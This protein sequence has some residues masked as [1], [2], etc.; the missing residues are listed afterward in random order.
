MRDMLLI[1]VTAAAAMGV[2]HRLRLPSVPFLVLAG[3]G[4]AALGLVHDGNLFQEALL[5]G[6]AFLVF[7]AGTEM[8]P[9]RM[10]EQQKAA[11]Q[12][13]LAQ[14]LAFMFIGMVFGLAFGFDWL[15]ALYLALALAASSTLIVIRLLKQRQQLFEP[16]GRLV[17]GVL[18]LQDGLIILAIAALSGV[19]GELT[20]VLVNVNA[21]LG[22]MLLAYISLRWVTPWLLLQFELDEEEKLL[23]ALAILFLFI[24]AASLI[25]VPVIIGAFLA[26]VALSSF[27]VSGILRGQLASLSDFFTALFFVTLGALLTLPTGRELLLAL[28][29]TAVVLLFT[30]ILVNVIARRAGVSARS[31]LESGFLL[32]QTSEFSLILG[33]IGIQQGHL[34]EGLLS[35]LAITTVLTMMATPLV[36]ADQVTIRLIHWL[37]R[38][39]ELTAP[40]LPGNHILLL[41]CGERGRPLLEWL[42]EQGETVVVVDDDATIIEQVRGLGVTA[43]HG[44]AANP[45]VLAAAGA[46]QAGVIVSTLKRLANNATLLG[47]VN[48]K[49]I[50]LTSFDPQAAH[51]IEQHGARAILESYAAVDE[52]AAWFDESFAGV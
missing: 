37:A 26:G 41:G 5:L 16:F 19:A 18:L 45:K 9:G 38:R 34:S 23:V 47:Y 48:Q 35:I 15:T 33:I 13:G 4:V 6:L 42:L 28:I 39:Q 29:L 40:P 27:P 52:F 8:N 10:G 20:A 46:L 50:F 7:S 22:L 3:S 17:V 12:V 31:A 30:P 14:F 1:L 32:A 44:D 43:I 36:A 49:P 24:A 21:T 51:Q 25:D 2:A 11:I